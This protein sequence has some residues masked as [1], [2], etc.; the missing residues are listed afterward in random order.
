MTLR[1]RIAAT[2][3]AAGALGAG[4]TLAA[5]SLDWTVGGAL[6]VSGAVLLGGAGASL[7]ASLLG[8]RVEEHLAAVEHGGE[9]DEGPGPLHWAALDARIASLE[10]ALKEAR[11]SRRDF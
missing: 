7:A 4:L 6:G 1:Q 3:A 2:G 9:T 11:R 10:S 8:R 5:A